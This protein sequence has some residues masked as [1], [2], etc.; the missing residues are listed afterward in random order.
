MSD[1]VERYRHLCEERLDRLDDYLSDLHGKLAS[2]RGADGHIEG[3][4]S[5]DGMDGKHE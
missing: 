4:T 3:G 5:I 2:D 1:W